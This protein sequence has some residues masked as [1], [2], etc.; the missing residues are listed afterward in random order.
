[1]KVVY[2]NKPATFNLK[3]VPSMYLTESVGVWVAPDKWTYIL[4]YG[5][6]SNTTLM[7]VPCRKDNEGKLRQGR[8]AWQEELCKE[9]PDCENEIKKVFSE[10][11]KI[12]SNK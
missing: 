7:A 12:L 6:A 1:M 10:T 3:E 8:W 2:Q 9:F 5:I 11:A 4:G